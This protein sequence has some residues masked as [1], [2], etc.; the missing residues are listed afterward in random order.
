V[1]LEDCVN[2]PDDLETISPNYFV[3]GSAQYVND[4]YYLNMAKKYYLTTNFVV[5]TPTLDNELTLK[6]YADTEINTTAKLASANTFTANQSI[7][8]DLSVSGLITQ[9]NT[10]RFKAY[11]NLV[12][13]GSSVVSSGN[14]IPYNTTQYDIGNGYD[15]VNYKYVV[16]VAGTYFFGG[17]WFKNSS[18][19]YIVDYQKNGTTIRRDESC[20]ELGAFSIIPTFLIE[21]CVV[22]DEIRLRVVSGSIRVG[23]TSST[24]PNG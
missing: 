4:H 3:N 14:N 13:G 12:D 9:S 18:N 11:Y 15:G 22:G 23:Y 1:I 10:I 20:Y 16:P 7:T 24:A 21:D 2:I 8:G 6:F 19:A 17:S 5:I